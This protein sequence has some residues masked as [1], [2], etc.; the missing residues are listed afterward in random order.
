MRMLFQLLLIFSFSVKAAPAPKPTTS[1]SQNPLQNVAKVL[2]RNTSIE[3]RAVVKLDKDFVMY[4]QKGK[5]VTMKGGQPL[6]VD[7]NETGVNINSFGVLKVRLYQ[8]LPGNRWVY[9]DY[10]IKTINYQRDGTVTV[11]TDGLALT[12]KTVEAQVRAEVIRMFGPKLQKS[13]QELS[14]MRTHQH[15]SQVEGGIDS[16]IKTMFYSEPAKP[17]SP[18]PPSLDVQ[19]E[20]SLGFEKKEK[21]K[22]DDKTTLTFNA[23]DSNEKGT[24]LSLDMRVQYNPATRKQDTSVNG[25]SF[26]SRKGVRVELNV[27]PEVMSATFVQLELTRD[28]LKDRNEMKWL[29]YATG[30]DEV[31]GG[32]LMAFGAVLARAGMNP[33]DCPTPSQEAMLKA[34][35]DCRMLLEIRI[36]VTQNKALLYKAGM[37]SQL[38]ETLANIKSER[39]VKDPTTGKMVNA[40]ST[41]AARAM[42]Q[43]NP[44]K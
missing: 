27:F 25:V 18:P 32:F 29:T 13:F 41:A 34:T 12:N 5:Q 44:T 7:F 31:L 17:N 1:Y 8:N 11:D 33:A 28:S 42:L 36:F 30:A 6:T 39:I 3:A 26:S 24:K 2:Q 35:V 16:I 10:P 9:I 15:I 23:D 21:V 20:F 14:K 19:M 40:C 22:L 38:L 37:N 4:D 43:R